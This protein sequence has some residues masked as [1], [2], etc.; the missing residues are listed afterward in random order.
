MFFAFAPVLAFVG[1]R[2]VLDKRELVLGEP[3]REGRV[4]GLKLE[5]RAHVLRTI[6]AKHEGVLR[7]QVDVVL[8]DGVGGK[9]QRRCG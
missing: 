5:P 8:G 2:G 9:Q 7:H 6:F 3:R 1:V 4:E